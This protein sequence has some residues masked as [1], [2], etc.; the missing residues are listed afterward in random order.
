[1][2]TPTKITVVRLILTVFILFVK[3]DEVLYERI[4]RVFKTN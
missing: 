4:R 2:N 3:I 1:M